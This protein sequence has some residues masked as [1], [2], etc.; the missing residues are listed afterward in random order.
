LAGFAIGFVAW[1]ATRAGAL[2][3]LAVLATSLLAV[4]VDRAY[5]RWLP[6]EVSPVLTIERDGVTY[7]DTRPPGEVTE[8]LEAAERAAVR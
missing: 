3:V 6:D 8:A 4:G 1:D 5:D 7:T 2:L